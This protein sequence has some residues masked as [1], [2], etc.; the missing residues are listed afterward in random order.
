MTAAVGEAMPV[1]AVDVS[2]A[3]GDAERLRR[4]AALADEAS[5]A[6]GTTQPAQWYGGAA[7]AADVARGELARCVDDVRRLAAA[8]ADAVASYAERVAPLLVRMRWAAADLEVALRAQGAEYGSER[9]AALVQAA[10]ADY[11]A[12]QAAYRAAVQDAV[13]AL[14]A[15]HAAAGPLA[16]G[17]SRHLA[18][19]VSRFWQDAVA[20]PVAGVWSLTGAFVTDR[21]AWDEAVAG[22]VPGVLAMVRHP[23]R[24]LDEMVAGPDWRAGEWG[25]AVG[26]TLA[27][28]VPIGKLRPLTPEER[29]R[30]ARNMAD[31]DAPR[32]RLQALDELFTTV[33]LD[34][35]EHYALGHTLRRHVDV[36]DR[37]LRD[38]LVEGT[39]FDEGVWG[40]VPRSGTASAWTDRATA[41]QWIAETLRRHEADVR[42]WAAD[43]TGVLTLTMTVPEDVGRVLCRTTDGFETRPPSEVVVVL[44]RDGRSVYIHTAY[45]ELSERG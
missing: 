21:E 34:A 43:G 10:W 39:V 38:R 25:A 17:P 12:V 30:H 42:Q 13:A 29:R 23:V 11:E 37:Y 32:P 5:G 24:T 9:A 3:R 16:H 44:A 26:G 45:P 40:P 41:E 6:V 15:V 20:D 27:M 7:T 19:G 22:V 36:G 8:A 2:A 33:D 4:A 35:S 1:P 18:A 28:A 31:P 14:E